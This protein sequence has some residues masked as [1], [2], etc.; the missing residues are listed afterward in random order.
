[1]VDLVKGKGIGRS[2]GSS[3]AVGTIID[4]AVNSV[5]GKALLQLPQNPRQMT[6]AEITAYP[7]LYAQLDTGMVIDKQPSGDW[8]LSSIAEKRLRHWAITSDG[9]IIQGTNAANYNAIEYNA[10]VRPYTQTIVQAQNNGDFVDHVSMSADGVVRAFIF[11]ESVVAHARLMVSNNSGATWV[12]ASTT[13]SN[14]ISYT[15][16]NVVV[17]RDG[18]T[19]TAFVS[20]IWGTNGKYIKITTARVTLVPSVTRLIAMADLVGTTS[21]GYN[22]TVGISDDGSTIVIIGSNSS[23]SLFYRSIDSGITFTDITAN[24]PLSLTERSVSDNKYTSITIDSLNSNRWIIQN[25]Y[26]ASSAFYK[27]VVTNDNGSTFKDVKLND[28]YDKDDLFTAASKQTG[29]NYNY[30]VDYDNVQVNSM[31]NGYTT[32]NGLQR[33]YF[34]RFTDNGELIN[35]GALLSMISSGAGT[36]NITIST[37]SQT[38]V[39]F[40]VDGVSFGICILH[41]VVNNAGAIKGTFLSAAS[42]KIAKFLPAGKTAQSKIVAE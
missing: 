42:G 38:W 7:L 8:D 19:I 10:T 26:S 29:N 39:D 4:S 34:V 24:V 25:L 22:E 36:S 41:S 17:S 16:G 15:G 5:N 3:I 23:G 2:S 33:A 31:H 37:P 14:P 27:L 32:L 18:N 6:A 28:I 12:A 35:Y 21:F 1:M 13:G 40:S 30:K 9:N 20:N 11:S